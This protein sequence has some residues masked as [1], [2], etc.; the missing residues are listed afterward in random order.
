MMARSAVVAALHVASGVLPA[1][2]V[3][4]VGLVRREALDDAVAGQHPTID[5]K[6]AAHHKGPHGGVLLGQTVGR[7][8]QISL[9]FPTVHQNQAGEAVGV[10]VALIGGILPSTTT[11][12]AFQILHVVTAHDDS[13]AQWLGVIETSAGSRRGS[14]MKDLERTCRHGKPS[15]RAAPPRQKQGKDNA[16]RKM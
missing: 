16:S 9:V 2:L 12:E 14:E 11:A 4:A 1:A 3:L 6:V 15:P 10:A 7:V 8:G 13:D 5:G